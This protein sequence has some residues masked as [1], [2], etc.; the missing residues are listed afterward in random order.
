MFTFSLLL[1]SSLAQQPN[2]G[3]GLLIV[4]VRRS[5][6][7]ND[8]PQSSGLVCLNLTHQNTLS[9]N[10]IVCVAN[11]TKADMIVYRSCPL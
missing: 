6:T 8:T 3:Q 1:F 4:E 10:L 9:S 2:A 5:H 7:Q 11:V